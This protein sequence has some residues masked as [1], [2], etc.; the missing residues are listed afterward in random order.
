[1]S[2]AA[3]AEGP[4]HHPSP[5]ALYPQE[6]HGQDRAARPGE[7][8]LLWAQPCPAP[9]CYPVSTWGQRGSAPGQGWGWQGKGGTKPAQRGWSLQNPLLPFR[10]GPVTVLWA[11]GNRV[12]LQRNRGLSHSWRRNLDGS[13]IRKSLKKMLEVLVA[14]YPL[15]D[16]WALP[17][18]SAVGKSWSR[19]S[20]GVGS[21]W[22]RDA[23][24]K[25]GKHGGLPRPSS[26]RCIY[27]SRMR[28]CAARSAG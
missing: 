15:S 23:R 4:W 3:Y 18:V 12:W 14:Q 10:W 2:R 8:A 21:S 20:G 26:G 28:G 1:M 9:R 24:R 22:W 16:V 25:R 7:A 6:P 19:R 27:P 11:G 13:I 17:G 5:L